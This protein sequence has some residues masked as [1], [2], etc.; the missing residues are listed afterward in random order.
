MQNKAGPTANRV[1][2]APQAV[3]VPITNKERS[4]MH[5]TTERPTALPT[6]MEHIH[7]DDLATRLAGF[8]LTDADLELVVGGAQKADTPGASRGAKALSWV[9]QFFS[10]ARLV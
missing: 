3:R 2:S 1:R 4:P 8:E 5:N 6:G 10:S 9:G 7:P